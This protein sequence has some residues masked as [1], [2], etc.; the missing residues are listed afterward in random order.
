M[1]TLLVE[2]GDDYSTISFQYEKDE[3]DSIPIWGDS[4]E[5]GDDGEEKV[6]VTVGK[7]VFD[8]AGIAV[9][10]VLGVRPLFRKD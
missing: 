4:F 3:A 10:E 7:K 8:K 1:A 9:Y 2:F 5:L 6:T